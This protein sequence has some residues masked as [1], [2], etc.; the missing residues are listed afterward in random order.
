MGDAGPAQ[1][2]RV[3]V[4]QG[5]RVVRTSDLDRALISKV[6]FDT[7]CQRRSKIR[8]FG[9]SK[10]TRAPRC[11]ADGRN[12]D[13][14]DVLDQVVDGWSVVGSALNRFKIQTA[15][16]AKFKQGI[17]KLLV[18]G[19]HQR[20]N[21]LLSYDGSHGGILLQRRRRNLF[22]RGLLLLA[23]QPAGLIGEHQ[24]DRPVLRKIGLKIERCDCFICVFS[25][26]DKKPSFDKP[27]ATD[28][29]S[30]GS[31]DRHGEFVNRGSWKL[32]KMV[33][34]RRRCQRDLS[35]AA[36]PRVSWRKL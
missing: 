15:T 2:V 6:L 30:F 27:M 11:L 26:I 28:R 18:V 7:C 3:I 9:N 4:E 22:E 16:V 35:S 8:I 32:K 34:R 13:L 29:R 24:H 12:S 33:Q 1:Q 21:D 31:P 20:W 17:G 19:L 25:L 10:D 36:E 5:S 23:R 14:A